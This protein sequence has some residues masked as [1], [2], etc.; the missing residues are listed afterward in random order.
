MAK[1]ELTD[2]GMFTKLW[3]DADMKYLQT[4]ID[5]SA[6]LKTN[7]NFV[8]QN[9]K[10]N[11]NIVP[12]GA[13]GDM[14]FTVRQ[15]INEPDGMADIK[16]ALAKNI[17]ID[18]KGSSV[19]SGT[20][21]NFGRA[22]NPIT[23]LDLEQKEKVMAQFGSDSPLVMDYIE[24]IQI[25]KNYA[26]SRLSNMAGQIMSTGKIKAYN[27]STNGI[28]MYPLDAQVPSANKVTAG[29][30]VWSASD[31]NILDQMSKIET[32][33]RNSTGDL[34]PMKWQIPL[35]MWR[36]VFLTNSKLKEDIIAWR[37]LNDMT[38]TDGKT[39]ME[40]WVVS[41]INNIGLTSPIEV[42]TEGGVEVGEAPN[43]RKDVKG[44]AN[45]VAVLR[46]V[47]FA[48]D[49]LHGEILKA[50]LSSKYASGTVQKMVAYINGGIYALINSIKYDDDG[51]PVLHTDME[52]C[53]V[54]VLTETPA[55]VIVDTATA[56]A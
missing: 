8:Y 38:T 49:I 23:V 16:G 4:F 24:N 29:T 42:I 36:N 35:Y 27:D 56:D 54:P 2:L 15:K 6:M 19:Y 13:D 5:N 37:K 40:E 51:Y 11:P 3:S 44:W 25:L 14:S 33:Y 39:V 9:F 12:I 28:I 22:L 41:F 52:G 31:C 48:G 18:Q 21:T 43:A 1:F 10:V 30:K 20:L 46:P 32:N 17:A 53:A 45:T 26:D 7:Y 55:H 47:G 50:K 34:Q